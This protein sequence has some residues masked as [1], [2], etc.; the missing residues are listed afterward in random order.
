MARVVVVGAGVGGLATAIRA[1]QH[2]HD[3]E[4][5]EARASPGGLA[6]GLT[7]GGLRFDAGP[8]IL[9]DRPGLDWGFERLGMALDDALDLDHVE[10]VYQVE[11]GDGD[12]IRID[13]DLDRTAERFADRWS[14]S[15]DRYREFVDRT[16][17]VHER[18]RPLQWTPDPGPLDVVRAGAWRDIP[19]VL[20]SLGGVLDRAGLPDPVERAVAIWTYVAGQSPETAPSPL[21]LV[22][23]LIHEVGAYYPQGGIGTIPEALADRATNCGVEF[24]YDTEVQR[25]DVTDGAVTGVTVADGRH[26]DADA[27]VSNYSGVGT[28]LELVETVPDSVR[29]TLES[30]PLQ[31]PGV[32]AYLKVRGGGEPPYLRFRLDETGA[33]CRLLIQPAVVDPDR[34]RDGWCPARLLGPIPYEQAQSMDREGQRDYLDDLL[35]E[36]W[37]QAHVDDWELLDARV[38]DDWSEEFHLYRDSMNPVMTASFMRRGRMDHRSPHVE[39]LYLAGSSTHPGQ[40]VS[41]CLVSGIHA[42]DLLDGDLA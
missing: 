13:A 26:L 15:G 34:C 38:V 10:S 27:V 19:F 36:E 21:A 4:V 24:D 41:F 33:P 31:S 42:A 25:I 30:L 16:A 9:L 35:A 8:Y 28:Y 29:R 17:A 3:V 18:L 32:C 39:E 5:V 11:I 23:A 6:S 40:W 37:W 12:R 14:G 7:V 2:G 20:R 22:P 1:T